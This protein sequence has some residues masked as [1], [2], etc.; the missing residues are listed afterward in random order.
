MKN[1]A[2]LEYRTIFGKTFGKTFLRIARSVNGEHF[3]E[4]FETNF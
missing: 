2:V 1:E 4:I 3:Y